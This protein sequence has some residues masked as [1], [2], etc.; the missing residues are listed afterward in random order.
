MKSERGVSLDHDRAVGFMW[1]ILGLDQFG[2]KITH[3]FM[4]LA[5]IMISAE[6]RKL[7]DFTGNIGYIIISFTEMKYCY[8]SVK[9]Y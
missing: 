9:K 7:Y 3:N 4:V 1:K 6:I 5:D 8:I 2:R